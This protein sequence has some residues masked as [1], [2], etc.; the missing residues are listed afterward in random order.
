MTNCVLLL[1]GCLSDKGS[2]KDTLLYLRCTKVYK[3][4]GLFK[5]EKRYL[6][7]QVDAERTMFTMNETDKSKLP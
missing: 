2:R 1:L 5:K 6:I 4:T 7:L 3:T